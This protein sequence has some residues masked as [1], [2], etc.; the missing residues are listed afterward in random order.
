MYEIVRTAPFARNGDQMEQDTGEQ[1]RH[2]RGVL[3][4][5]PAPV[6]APPEHLIRPV[7]A[8]EDAGTEERPRDER[9]A[10]HRS[11]EARLRRRLYHA[12]ERVGKGHGEQCITD[13]DDR[14]M[15][16]HPRILQQRIHPMPIEYNRLGGNKRAFDKYKEGEDGSEYLI[17]AA[18]R[19]RHAPFLRQY[20]A[21]NGMNHEPE[22]E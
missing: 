7:T 11:E 8:D 17:D 1:P 19:W 15:H 9:P 21:D 20:H 12:L 10:T 13:E 2:K 6:A 16:R 3:H 18:S 4:G 14:R 22:Q 5:I